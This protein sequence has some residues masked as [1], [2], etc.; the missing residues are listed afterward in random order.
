MGAYLDES[1]N[2][3]ASL[4]IDSL[5]HLLFREA[6]AARQRFIEAVGYTVVFSQEYDVE[7]C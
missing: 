4:L 3:F 1:S 7:R 2:D 5:I 6:T